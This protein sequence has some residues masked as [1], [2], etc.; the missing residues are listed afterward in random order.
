MP[1]AQGDGGTGS[2]AAAPCSSSCT[3]NGL[4]VVMV[5]SEEVWRKPGW[6]TDPCG[7]LDQ[8]KSLGSANISLRR[9]VR[10]S[11]PLTH[12]HS[13]HKTAHLHTSFAHL[14]DREP[15]AHDQKQR[16]CRATPSEDYSELARTRL[17]ASHLR[18]MLQ[19]GWITNSKVYRGMYLRA[20]VE[21][22]SH[23]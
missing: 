16:W 13:Y 10:I 17:T 8:R 12:C 3:W 2:P 4:E 6:R 18:R 22:V 11:P 7:K 19:E 23:A 1:R 20:G 21:E 15:C 5:W 14:M 9:Q